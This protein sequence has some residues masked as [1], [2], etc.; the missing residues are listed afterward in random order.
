[1]E[2]IFGSLF[3]VFILFPLTFETPWKTKSKKRS[4][5][6]LP[7]EVQE[8]FIF[9]SKFFL[10]FFRYILLLRA[11]LSKTKLAVGQ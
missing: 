10:R 3:Q 1:M 9:S 6:E 5:K 2:N 8:M 4:S 7:R 11:P